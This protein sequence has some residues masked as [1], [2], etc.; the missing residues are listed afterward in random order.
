MSRIVLPAG[1]Q[2]DTARLFSMNPAIGK[3]LAGLSQAIYS[4]TVVDLRVREAVRMRIAH[5]NQCLLCI[6]FRFPQQAGQF[7]DAGIDETF[8][9]AVPFWRDSPMFTEREKTAIEYAELF[10][11]SHLAIDDAFFARLQ[12]HFS[13]EE[14]FTLTT[15]I[16]G[17]LANGRILQVLQVAQDSCAL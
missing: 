14:I 11:T 7:A 9:A 15:I 17:L 1:D 13:D 12:Q 16:A 10:A 8:Y 5:L 2:P 4:Q 6:G 3:A